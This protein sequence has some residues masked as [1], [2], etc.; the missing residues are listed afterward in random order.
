[1]ASQDPEAPIIGIQMALFEILN[2]EIE[3]TILNC[4][5]STINISLQIELLY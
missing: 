2:V 4:M 3:K 1:V 5:F